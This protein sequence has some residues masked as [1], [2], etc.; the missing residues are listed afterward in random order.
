[1]RRCSTSTR[2]AA[3]KYL[4]NEALQLMQ[5]DLTADLI[6]TTLRN[7]QGANLRSLQDVRRHGE[8]VAT[9]SPRVEQ[10]RL[11][12]KRYLYD[13]LYTCETLEAEHRK[14]E[15]VIEMIFGFY[16]EDPSRMPQGYVEAEQPRGPAPRVIADYIAGMTDSFILQQFWGASRARRQGA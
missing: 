2:D 13:T 7:V 10:L 11:E 5:N 1:M 8:R 16:L 14:A 9:F 15:H 4:F 12:E 6:A 3:E